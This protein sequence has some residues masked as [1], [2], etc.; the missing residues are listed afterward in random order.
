[1]AIS[2]P[3]RAM[4]FII[5]TT[6]VSFPGMTCICTLL[7]FAPITTAVN[8]QMTTYTT[9]RKAARKRLHSSGILLAASTMLQPLARLTFAEYRMRSEGV[10][11][12]RGEASLDARVS[13]DLGSACTQCGQLR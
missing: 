7:S 8:C 2:G 6:L 11:R 12:S 10:R 5:S 13:A 4:L 9:I 3:S 1:M